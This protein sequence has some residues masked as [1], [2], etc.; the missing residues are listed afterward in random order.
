MLCA[1]GKNTYPIVEDKGTESPSP[2]VKET[3]PPSLNKNHSTMETD[4]VLMWAERDEC[5]TMGIEDI[6]H[7]EKTEVETARASCEQEKER[8]R[9]TP[10][11]QTRS[12]A[13]K[14]RP[15]TLKDFSVLRERREYFLSKKRKVS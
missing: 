15:S 14:M 3:I 8:I 6:V 9:N 13:S 10:S 7:W 2:I 5:S 4:E 12:R 1:A 11:I